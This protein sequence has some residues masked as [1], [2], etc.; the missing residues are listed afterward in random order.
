L[1]L[2]YREVGISANR[3]TKDS[4]QT[5]DKEQ[6]VTPKVIVSY[7]D[8][9][10][11]QDA[12]ALGRRFREAG[13]EV[14]LAY[15][16]HSQA[17]DRD[18]EIREELAARSLLE[19]GARLLGDPDAKRHVV[20]NASTGDGLWALAERE[21]ADV[22]VFGSEY[23]TA[24]GTVSPLTST[25]RLLDGG[26]AA[27]AIAPAGFREL[28][29]GVSTI[30]G[31]PSPDDASAGDTARALAESLGAE[32]SM[33]TGHVDLLVIG[34]RPEAH[35]GHVMLTALAEYAIDLAGSPVLVVPR[36]EAVE[37]VAPVTA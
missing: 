24:P 19:H 5:S 3:A 26:P 8:T 21:G 31:Y 12:V 11:D 35:K 14:S 7:D 18:A 30:G 32:V 33:D 28:D 17:T 1:A 22:I 4:S 37:F 25:K 6:S 13:A 16:R 15:V 2:I 29:R 36:D 27:V 23:R 10:N 34:S 9:P 20:L